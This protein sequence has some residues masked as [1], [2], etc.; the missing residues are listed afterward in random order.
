MDIR[1]PSCSTLYE[2]DEDRISPK[3]VNV[4]CTACGQVFKV[5]TTTPDEPKVLWMVK[6]E[7]TG[8]VINFD[9]LSTLQRW[10]VEQKVSRR[11]S[12][13]KTGD[14]WKS[15]GSINELHAFFKVV[16]ELSESKHTLR[17]TDGYLTANQRASALASL[18]AP[19][20]ATNLPA[21]GT[22]LPDP[23]FAATQR[24]RSVSGPATAPPTGATRPPTSSGATP[25]PHPPS[26]STRALG[27]DPHELPGVRP[28]SQSAPQPTL[29]DAPKRKP[30]IGNDDELHAVAY[31]LSDE[32]RTPR[33]RY[34]MGEMRS[35]RES[36]IRF[37][38]PSLAPEGVG[39]YTA[40]YNALRQKR[41][42][43]PVLLL[44]LLLLLA[45]VLIVLAAVRP[46]LLGLGDNEPNTAPIAAVGTDANA[47]AA[48]NAADASGELNAAPEGS[49][50]ADGSG[51][52]TTDGSG[53]D[54]PE[55]SADPSAEPD[56]DAGTEAVAEVA[57]DTGAAANTAAAD[58]GRAATNAPANTGAASRAA[59]EAQ[60]EASERQA[61]RERA[62]VEAAQQ[63]EARQRAAARNAGSSNSGSSSGSSS[64][65]GGY[66]GQMSA[67][68]EALDAG[69][70]QEALSAF[71]E[72]ADARPSS[73]EAQV[74]VA[75]AY[76]RMGRHD[77]AA[78]RYE[79]AT[80]VN[81]R[82]TPAWLGLGDARRRN[83]DTAGACEA[84]ARVQ[85]I[86][87]TG[88][89]ASRAQEAA[90]AIGCE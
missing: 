52:P 50:A 80:S 65:S 56:T 28:A 23:A 89:S 24:I 22:N 36:S 5:R 32:D 45:G 7:T 82:Y 35:E 31:T 15:L 43:W 69:D 41:S 59:V 67:G 63:E 88:R 58:A 26:G 16:D 44:S 3:G 18:Q 66:D 54:A 4:R 84:Y 78:V 86:V 2:F 68:N 71:S 55:G 75:R 1:C 10:I 72:A 8:E 37:A 70:Y 29:A 49:G 47:L 73:A 87:R 6:R 76:E 13:S 38:A 19:P 34:S 27:V 74:G 30:K 14:T 39:D 90:A 57:P 21:N 83:G 64:R 33:E 62:A 53:Q 85:S 48:A 12:I 20:S 9:D 25:P 51:D 46:D 11:D 17:D 79:R 42:R 60:R 77:L 61:A 40:E 81:S